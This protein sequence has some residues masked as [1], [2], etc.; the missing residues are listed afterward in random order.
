LGTNA[1]T[2]G[3]YA[4]G[5]AKRGLETSW[6]TLPLQVVGRHGDTSEDILGAVETIRESSHDH[7]VVWS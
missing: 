2:S 4:R 1:S 5:M 7:T 6:A 3:H